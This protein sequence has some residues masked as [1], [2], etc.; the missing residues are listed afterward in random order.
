M[1]SEEKTIIPVRIKFSKT[2]DLMYISH[3][4]LART[5]QRIILRSGI[6]IWYSE[7]FNPQP[8]MVFAVPLPVGVESEC[9]LMDIKINSFM[10]NEEIMQRIN[11]NFPTQMKVIEVYNPDVKFKN[12]AY[13]DYDISITSPQISEKVGEQIV[14]LFSHECKIIKKTKSGEKELD[15]SEYI[16]VFE[17]KCNNDTLSI[18]TILPVGNDMNLNPELLID[19][20][21][22]H[23]G[24]LN[25][26]SPS[27][28]YSIMRK[29]MLGDDLKEF[30]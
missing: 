18:H 19:A 13:I 21:K 12:L 3:L 1:V 8:K 25:T 15:L 6:D 26:D 5:M 24:I 22:Q 10:S 2:G 17:L 23:I 7:G 16:K 30:R 14:S 29:K 4:D 20:I 28:H 9:E 11:D 27:E